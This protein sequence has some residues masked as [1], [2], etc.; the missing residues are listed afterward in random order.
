MVSPVSCLPGSPLWEAQDGDTAI[1]GSR[2]HAGGPDVHPTN[3]LADF[4]YT[5][6]RLGW[7]LWNYK[8]KS[9]MDSTSILSS[10]IQRED[11]S[12]NLP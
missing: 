5:D 11:L 6:W 12:M 2:L 1:A 9:V 4:L 7:V 3:V 10:L 8:K